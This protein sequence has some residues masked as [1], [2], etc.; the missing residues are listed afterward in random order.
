MLSD[1][2]SSLSFSLLNFVN[3]A[4]GTTARRLRNLGKR[5]LD[6]KALWDDNVRKFQEKGHFVLPSGQVLT[7]MQVKAFIDGWLGRSSEYWGELVKLQRIVYMMLHSA[8]KQSSEWIEASCIQCF[9][10][11]QVLLSILSFYQVDHQ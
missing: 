5:I 6:D 8:D 2:Y 9:A 4:S 1:D 10:I 11:S 3:M 7:T